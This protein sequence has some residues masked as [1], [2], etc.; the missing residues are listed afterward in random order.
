M[1]RLL[2]QAEFRCTALMISLLAVT[3]LALGTAAAGSIGQRI[4]AGDSAIG[5]RLL[6]DPQLSKIT[7]NVSGKINT[8]SGVGTSGVTITFSRVS[9][10][11]TLPPPAQT[12]KRGSWGQKGFEP[13]T[14][15]RATPSATGFSF[16]PGS[17]DFRDA[18]TDLNFQSLPVTFRV[19]GNVGTASTGA[20][21]GQNPPRTGIGGA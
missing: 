19:S 3:G 9:G 12:D 13:G 11:G 2:K 5:P 16:T 4:I 17:L 8:N 6:S 10:T 21:S 15:Y 18:R 14:A 20:S 1:K 7:F